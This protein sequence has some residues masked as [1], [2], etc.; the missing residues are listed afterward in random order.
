MIVIDEHTT[1]GIPPVS[2][3][4]PSSLRPFSNPI[5]TFAALTLFTAGALLTSAVFGLSDRADASIAPID[6]DRD[7][8]LEDLDNDGL[9]AKLEALLDTDPLLFDSDGDGY[10]DGMEVAI[11]SNPRVY[12]AMIPLD[13]SV[14]VRFFPLP[15][16]TLGVLFITFGARESDRVHRFRVLAGKGSNEAEV[17]T[18]YDDRTNAVR[19]N[20]TR[21]PSD[22]V[23]VRSVAIGVPLATIGERTNFIAEFHDIGEIRSATATFGHFGGEYFIET[24]S[25]GT[26][27]DELVG[28]YHFL[29]NLPFYFIPGIGADW[30]DLPE[31]AGGGG[32]DFVDERVFTET[33]MRVRRVGTIID[34]VI[35]NDCD[36][37]PD[38][39]CPT[40]LN[41]IG[42][43]RI[44]PGR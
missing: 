5:R 41:T 24:Y 36:D 35:D 29:G 39:R 22:N 21:L 32:S 10:D 2:R 18:T 42:Q 7:F 11:G 28:R 9:P 23:E 38:E 34:T 15:D 30:G 25:D 4:Q 3:R 19:R 44:G 1:V 31:F 27:P 6:H 14:A 40:D 13:S 33:I 8:S 37:D 17:E 26:M 12:D 43:I 16:D 20:G